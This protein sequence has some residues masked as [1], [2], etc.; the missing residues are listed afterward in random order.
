[1]RLKDI[2][3]EKDFWEFSDNWYQ[4]THRLREVWQNPREEESRKAKAFK[5]WLIMYDRVMK[6]VPI[7]TKISTHIPSNNFEKGGVHF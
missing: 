1:M 6:L 3:T 7:A 5:L 2:K 4:R